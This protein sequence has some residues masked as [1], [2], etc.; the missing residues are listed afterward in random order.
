MKK[1]SYLSALLL[2]AS[3]AFMACSSDDDIH[4]ESVVVD[5]ET[6]TLLAGDSIQLH[7][8]VLPANAD[9]QTIRWSSNNRAV[10]TVDPNTGMVTAVSGGTVTITAASLDRWRTSTV[11]ITVEFNISNSLSGVVVNDLRWA[12]RNLAAPGVFADSPTALGM[13]YQWNRPT[14]WAATGEHVIDWDTSIPEGATWMAENDPCPAGWR[15][16]TLAELESLHSAGGAWATYNDVNG[17]VFGTA[18]YQLFLPAVGWRLAYDGGALVN[19]DTDGAYWSSNTTDAAEIN[20]WTMRFNSSELRMSN[21]ARA[22]AFSIRCIA[23]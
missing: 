11:V 17:R 1:I 14:A 22:N 15:I 19:A 3:F 5:R 12:T 4:V 2:V 23:Q 21:N 9:N 10:A 16:P 20:A 6:Y 7:A 13:L 8:H 18:P